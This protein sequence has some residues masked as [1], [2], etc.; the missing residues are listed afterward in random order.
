M[1]NTSAF[2]VALKNNSPQIDHIY[3]KSKLY[4]P[5]FNLSKTDIN[6]IG[7]YRFVGATDN[8]R[9]RAEA[10]D[11]YFS[12]LKASHVD[13]KKHIIID[14][15]SQNP[16]NLRMDLQSYMEFRD[17]RTNEIYKIIEPKLNFI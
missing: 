8:L 1:N 13:I 14:S 10:A 3:P 4:K 17:S 9:K 5:P 12:R 2:N 6:H 7:N 16:N 15:F 11:S